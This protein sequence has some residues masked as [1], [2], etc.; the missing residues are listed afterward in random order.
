[1]DR[2][3]FDWSEHAG[4]TDSST[5][6]GRLP[7]WASNL[8]DHVDKQLLIMLRDGRNLIGWLRTFDHFANL[9]IEHT[10]E[11]HIIYE[12]RDRQH[13]YADIF[14][15]TMIIRGENVCLFGEVDHQRFAAGNMREAPLSYVLAREAELEAAEVARSGQPR[16][17]DLFGDLYDT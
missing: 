15:G 13:I 3:V 1:M 10:V 8:E 6:T 2:P 16:P 11:R 4:T 9:V 14:L 17:A 5:P 7:R 12:E